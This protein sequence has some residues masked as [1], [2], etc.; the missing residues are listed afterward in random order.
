MASEW[1][2]LESWSKEDLII[3]LVRM[4]HLYGMF[5]EDMDPDDPLVPYM[6]PLHYM[7][8]DEYVEGQWTTDEWAE[9]IAIYGA[10]HPKDGMFY[11]CDLEDYGLTN[12]QAYEVCER[13]HREGRLKVPDGIGYY[14]SSESERWH[15]GAGRD[16]APGQAR[17]PIPVPD[18]LRDPAR[19]SIRSWGGGRRVADAR[20]TA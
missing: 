12:D 8:G 9:R 17:G 3:E 13:L 16:T 10:M 4:R 5:R 7:E 15:A 2:E 11:Y 1:E 20:I 18:I 6:E 14:D 19:P